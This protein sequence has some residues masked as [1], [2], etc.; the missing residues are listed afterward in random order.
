MPL[1]GLIVYL[2]SQNLFKGGYCIVVYC[3]P[4]TLYVTSVQCTV[5]IIVPDCTG[6][7]TH[8]IYN[9]FMCVCTYNQ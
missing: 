5:Y 6:I 2:V 3:T 8:N 4:L 7:N 9:I 1:M